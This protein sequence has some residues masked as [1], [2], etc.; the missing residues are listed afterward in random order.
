MTAHNRCEE[1]TGE[2]SGP[3]SQRSAAVGPATHVAWVP[4]TKTTG[5]PSRCSRCRC[6]ALKAESMLYPFVSQY[7]ASRTCPAESLEARRTPSVSCAL[8]LRLGDLLNESS[9][10]RTAADSAWDHTLRVLL[11]VRAQP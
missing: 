3:R 8:H 9:H 7:L 6:W 1:S 4:G 2:V 5:A 10:R 11:A